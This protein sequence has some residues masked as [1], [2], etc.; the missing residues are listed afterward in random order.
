MIEPYETGD[1]I[2]TGYYEAIEGIFG[3]EK[4]LISTILSWFRRRP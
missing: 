1:Y 2:E 3:D 4:N